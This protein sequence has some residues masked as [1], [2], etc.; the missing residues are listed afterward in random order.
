MEIVPNNPKRIY[1]NIKSSENRKTDL[2]YFNHLL[3]ENH[4]LD[5]NLEILHY[6]NKG[7]SQQFVPKNHIIF[8]VLLLT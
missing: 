6:E 2:N 7:I 4:L 3:Q 5:P 1:Q 8:T